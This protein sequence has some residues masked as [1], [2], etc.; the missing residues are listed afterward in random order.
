MEEIILNNCDED[1]LNYVTGMLN[2]KN[3]LIQQ[4]WKYYHAYQQ[5]DKG[6]QGYMDGE[7]YYR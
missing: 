5:E 7:E 1:L 6:R 4:G 3:L 2:N